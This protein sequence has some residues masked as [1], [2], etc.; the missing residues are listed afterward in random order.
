[1]CPCDTPNVPSDLACRLAAAAAAE[2]ADIA[3]AA[4]AERLHPLHALIPVDAAPDLAAYLASGGRSVQGWL[5]QHRVAIARFD[6]VGEP[7]ANANTADE[8]AR[9][10]TL[11]GAR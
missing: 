1:V 5:A 3:I 6:G 8:L 7:F 4:D 9:L 2:K 11:L 10:A